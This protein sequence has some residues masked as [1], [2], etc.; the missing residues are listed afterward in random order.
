MDLSPPRLAMS[1][2]LR[3]FRLLQPWVVQLDVDIVLE[4]IELM[5]GALF[6]AGAVTILSP[7]PPF[8]TPFSQTA[9]LGV[10]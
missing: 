2:K 5:P 1:S 10:W 3:A 6:A 7:P 4:K 8:P 9:T